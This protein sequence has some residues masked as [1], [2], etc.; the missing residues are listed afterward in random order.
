[1]QGHWVNEA[2]SKVAECDRKLAHYRAALD[3]GASPATV[4][5]WIA[6]TEAEKARYAVSLRQAPKARKRMTEQEIRSVVDKLAKIAHVLADADPNDKSE[7]FR[8]LGLK[9]TYHP[10]RRIVE[11]SIT[12]A[13]HGF[14]ESVRGPKPTNCAWWRNCSDQ[15]F[16]RWWCLVM[17]ADG[18]SGGCSA[19]ASRRRLRRM[20]PTA[21]GAA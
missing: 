11:A 17:A 18:S 6:E 9:L 8:Q 15:V 20:S 14:F 3:A 21:L 13:P 4:V 7:I 10:G 5:G 2:A 12:P 1:M 19:L 16:C